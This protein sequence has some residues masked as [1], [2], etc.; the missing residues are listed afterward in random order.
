M[1]AQNNTQGFELETS[2][3]VLTF[4]QDTGQLVSFRAKRAPDPDIEQALWR[5]NVIY[6]AHFLP[7]EA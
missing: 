7:E 6:V 4:D 3:D 1:S 5:R 2:E